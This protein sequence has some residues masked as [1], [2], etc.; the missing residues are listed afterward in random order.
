[1]IL[2]SVNLKRFSLE[3]ASGM[4]AIF[5]VSCNPIFF[6]QPFAYSHAFTGFLP[7]KYLM[8][9]TRN[10][11]ICNLS[12]VS[13][14]QIILNFVMKGRHISGMEMKQLNKVKNQKCVVLDDGKCETTIRKQH[15]NME[16][17][18][19]NANNLLKDRKMLFKAN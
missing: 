2:E 19:F 9:T 3:L 4:F 14:V 6:L 10:Q 17:Y 15:N 18:L 16:K 5:K 13:R 11:I 8:T 1:M 12:N 7:Q